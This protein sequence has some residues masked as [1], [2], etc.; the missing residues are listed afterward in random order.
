M[1]FQGKSVC[2][3]DRYVQHETV[4]IRHNVGLSSVMRRFCIG[5]VIHVD[6]CQHPSTSDRQESKRDQHTSSTDFDGVFGVTAQWSND[7]IA[8]ESRLLFDL[9]PEDELNLVSNLRDEMMDRRTKESCEAG[10]LE[11]ERGDEQLLEQVLE[12]HN[13]N[14]KDIEEMGTTLATCSIYGEKDEGLDLLNQKLPWE[15]EDETCISSE[16]RHSLGLDLY[17]LWGDV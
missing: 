3:D 1:G 11:L 10:R 17:S 13:V 15:E 14:E 5:F 12:I 4:C 6:L 2:L 8:E 16:G 7:N 9:V